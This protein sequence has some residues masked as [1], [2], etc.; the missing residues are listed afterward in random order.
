MDGMPYNR[1]Y[2]RVDDVGDIV[3]GYS[4]AFRQPQ[5]GD[6]CID[7]RGD[8]QFRLWPDGEE[9]PQ[10][11]DMRGICLYRYANGKIARKPDAEIEAEAA[12]P[13]GAHSW[14]SDD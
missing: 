8:R 1:H 12:A 10:L 6:I 2:I 5:P 4:D 13:P 9:N 7:E 3:A 14:G 11:R